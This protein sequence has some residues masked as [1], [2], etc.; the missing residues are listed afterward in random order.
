MDNRS[1]P[2]CRYREIPC[3][4]VPRNGQ[5]KLSLTRLNHLP[6]PSTSRQQSCFSFLRPTGKYHHR[7]DRDRSGGANLPR[8]DFNTRNRGSHTCRSKEWKAM[9]ARDQAV[10][11]ARVHWPPTCQSEA[12]DQYS[13]S[14][15]PRGS[16]S[17][18]LFCYSGS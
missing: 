7:F 13:A 15:S 2:F 17:N 8:R 3:A 6:D 11:A 4:I 14:I 16:S 9:R 18:T 10:V 1:E 5:F 12:L